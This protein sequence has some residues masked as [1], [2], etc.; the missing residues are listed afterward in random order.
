MKCTLVYENGDVHSGKLDL[1]LKLRVN[2]NGYLV[3]TL[4]QEQ[5]SIHRLVKSTFFT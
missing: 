3:V 4:D 1:L 5:L 2:P